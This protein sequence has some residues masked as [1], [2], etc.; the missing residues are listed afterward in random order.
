ADGARLGDELARIGYLGSEAAEAFPV[1][2]SF[3]AHIEQGPVLETEA[4]QIGVVTGVQGMRWYD[5]VIDGTPCHA[6]TTPMAHRRDP[7]QVL[8]RALTRFFDGL[9]HFGPDARATVGVLRSV[10]E[11]RNTVPAQV[12]TSVDLRHPDAAVL[13]A[14]EASLRD[15]LARG[16]QESETA[17]SLT[18]VWDSPAVAFDTGCVAAVREAASTRGYRHRDIVSGAGHDSVYLSRVAPTA[19]IFVPCEGGLSH[20]EA[21]NA[22]PEDIAAGCD[23]LLHAVLARDAVEPL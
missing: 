2:G 15:L 6:G 16:S 22:T 18:C 5:L 3:E 23:V 11:S 1:H 17:A 13:E 10:P 21:E 12:A 7:T 19:M 14:M 9:D 20:N 4:L 8:V